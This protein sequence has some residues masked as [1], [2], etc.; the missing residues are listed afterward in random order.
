MFDFPPIFTPLGIPK[1]CEIRAFQKFSVTCFSIL[2][3][4]IPTLEIALS[5]VL[6][7]QLT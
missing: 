2:L 7:I 5:A 1:K 4:P 3:W 6:L